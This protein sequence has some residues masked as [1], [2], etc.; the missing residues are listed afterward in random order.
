MPAEL[1]PATSCHAW[2]VTQAVALGRVLRQLPPYLVV[3]GIE[4]R[5]FGLGQ[6]RSPEV[7]RSIPEVAR[8]IWQEIQELLA[9][10]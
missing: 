4:G 2:G 8:R 3:Y 9:E 10:E 1:F 5:Y 6:D 7:A